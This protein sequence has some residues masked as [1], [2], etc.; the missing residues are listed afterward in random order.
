MMNVYSLNDCLCLVMEVHLCRAKV[1][2]HSCHFYNQVESKFTA[3]LLPECCYLCCYRICTKTRDGERPS[4][5]CRRACGR[6]ST[7]WVHQICRDTGVSVTEALLLAEDRPFWQTIAT[8][9]GSG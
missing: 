8:A 9:E 5:E 6:P 2:A 1:A 3:L 7:T 4:Q